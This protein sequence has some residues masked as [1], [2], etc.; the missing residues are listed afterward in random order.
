MVTMLDVFNRENGKPGEF[1][2]QIQRLVEQKMKDGGVKFNSE[3]RANQTPGILLTYTSP[4]LGLYPSG[5]KDFVEEIVQPEFN[6]RYEASSL[7][8]IKSVERI[9]VDIA[10][11]RQ[12]PL[13][14]YDLFIRVWANQER[15]H[16]I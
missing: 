15:F 13:V 6:K 3:R 11:N 2:A 8:F 4:M 12:L 1:C 9:T 16:A 5:V 10:E 14:Q 7:R